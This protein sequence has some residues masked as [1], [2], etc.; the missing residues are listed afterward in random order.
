MA[1]ELL[2]KFRDGSRPADQARAL[3]VL[4]SIDA[5]QSRW[6][7]DVLLVNTPGEPDA[8]QAA[9]A[10]GMQPEVEW[11][12]PNWLRRYR[13]V[14]NDPQYSSQWNFTAIGMP[15]AWDINPGASATIKVAVL[16]TGITTTTQTLTFKTWTGSQFE[17][18]S[19]PFAADPDI[20]AARILPGRDFV[21]WGGAVFDSDGHGS[22]VAGTILEDTNNNFG[23]AGIAYAATLLPVKA[24]LS[25]WDLQFLRGFSNTPGFVDP[26][27]EGYCDDS[28]L[29]DGM[30]YAADQGAQIINI[31]VG[32]PGAAPILLDAMRYAVSHGA[33]ISMAA[34]NDYGDGNPTEYPA[35][36]A[37]QVNGAVAV[38][39]VGRSLRRAFYSSTGSYVEL[40]APGG[41]D[42]DGGTSGM[43]WQTTLLPGD[44]D[45]RVVRPRFDRYGSIAYEGTSMAAPHV[46]GAAA[47]LYSQ[48]ITSPAAIESALEQF[49]TDLGVKGRDDQ[50]G[51]GLINVR[52]ALRGLGLAK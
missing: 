14:P 51:Y 44:S 41:D 23:A 50:Y 8:G 10:V 49:A 37:T 28:A 33:F 13:A 6:I 36:Y 34:G 39:A 40:V 24:C 43:I 5:T 1:G 9:A 18:L 11:A 12:Q 2:V 46:S 22:H 16:D 26:S 38:G 3:S 31:S 42:T 15:Q 45:P 17:N 4:R 27:E 30:R 52:A 29:A 25:H 20:R 35:A 19:V 32:G 21:F 7:G 48:G 47:L